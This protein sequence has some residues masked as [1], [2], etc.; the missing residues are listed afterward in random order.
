MSE[1]EGP[2]YGTDIKIVR[3]QSKAEAARWARR[4]EDR[5]YHGWNIRTE[6]GLPIFPQTRVYQTAAD[7]SD[8]DEDYYNQD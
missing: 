6:V 1:D 7:E 8:F 2:I 3:V 5:Q 4:G